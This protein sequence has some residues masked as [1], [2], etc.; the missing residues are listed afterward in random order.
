[1]LRILVVDQ[2]GSHYLSTRGAQH[3]CDRVA[4]LA[5][6]SAEWILT[7]WA[8]SSLGAVV[9]GMNA[10]W[11]RPE[12][13]YGLEHSAPKV[14]IADA[15]RR[16]NVGELAADR[17]IPVLSIEDDIVRLATAASAETELPDAEI[18]ED[19]PAVILYTSGTTGR[20]KG[21]VHSH[22]NVIAAV[23]FFHYNDEVAAAMATREG[24]LPEVDESHP[25]G[26]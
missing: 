23:D 5:A 25:E 6:N 21:A 3:L 20:P 7:F 19:D 15:R 10:F 16:E 26:R 8:V 13:G 1:M 17:G 9:V 11:S 22:R 24:V 2:A 18:D 14:L 12:I 4:I